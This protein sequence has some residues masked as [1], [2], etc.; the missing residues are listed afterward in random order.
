MW[1]RTR[2]G[3]AWAGERDWGLIRIKMEG[4]SGHLQVTIQSETVENAGHSEWSRR[5]YQ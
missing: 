2:V 4:K 5:L 1:V 3:E